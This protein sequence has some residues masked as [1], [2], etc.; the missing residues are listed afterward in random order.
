MQQRRKNQTEPKQTKI[1]NNRSENT[2][3]FFEDIKVRD[4]NWNKS[5]KIRSKIQQRSKIRFKMQNN[6]VEQD[7][8]MK[9]TILERHKI[10]TTTSQTCT[11]DKQHATKKKKQHI[12]K[13]KRSS[14]SLLPFHLKSIQ[15]GIK[16]VEHENNQSKQIT[17]SKQSWKQRP[18]KQCPRNEKH[19]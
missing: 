17:T 15:K 3:N 16:K 14:S 7:T 12:Q 18:A 1:V 11:N 6:T 13:V 9:T 2:S 4:P 5:K 8:T 19:N 10:S